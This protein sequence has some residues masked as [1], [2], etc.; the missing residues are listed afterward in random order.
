MVKN[1]KRTWSGA[2]EKLYQQIMA[3]LDY[4]SVVTQISKNVNSFS[5]RMRQIAR[6]Y[7]NYVIEDEDRNDRQW[8]IDLGG[9]PFQEP[10]NADMATNLVQFSKNISKVNP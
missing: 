7:P 2:I 8:H 5:Q 6:K 1:T 9:I 10:S 3:D 4:K